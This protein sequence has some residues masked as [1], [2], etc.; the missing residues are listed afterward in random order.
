MLVFF[1]VSPNAGYAISPLERVFLEVARRVVESDSE[2]HFAYPDLSTGRPACLPEE[3]DRVL[4]FDPRVSDAAHLR[5]TEEYV[6]RHNIRIA[7][8]FD[9]P[10]RRPGY[11]ALRRGGIRSFVSYWGAPMSSLNRGWKRALKRL[12]VA[13]ARHGP[14]HYIFESIGMRRTAIEGRG[15]PE[16][17]TSVTYLGVDPERYHP[18][19]RPDWYAHDLFKIPRDRRIVYFSGHMEARKG[20]DILVKATAELVNERLRQNIHLVVLGNRS[21]ED[22]AFDH[23]YRGTQA[24]GHITF[25]GYRDDVPR[26]LAGAYV[27][28]IG[29][30]GWDSFTMSSVEMAACGIPLVVSRL[31]GLDETV[32]DGK[33]GFTFPV[34]DHSALANRLAQLIDD[35]NLRRQM[36][37]AS[38]ERAVERFTILR[39]VD[40][41]ASTILEVDAAQTRRLGVSAA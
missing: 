3:F 30:T 15:V 10:V 8:G 21:G 40:E 26:I 33:T 24:E 2:I 17:K 25:G 35:P 19:E 38:R 18:P 39:Q 6:R 4:G 32:D 7:L 16:S 20:V 14:D 37:E 36:S 23:L 13:L 5:S 12:D 9:Q 1:H 29:S 27:G 22:K 41:L 31:A 34:G 28:A 11:A